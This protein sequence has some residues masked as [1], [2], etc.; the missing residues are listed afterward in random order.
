MSF[1]QS[2]DC[3][4]RVQQE[5]DVYNALVPG[6]GEL[7]ATLFIE[8]PELVRMSQDEVRETVNRFQGLEKDT[9]WMVAVTATLLKIEIGARTTTHTPKRAGEPSARGSANWMA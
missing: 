9:V 6:Q 7:S 4:A 2:P 5:L 1:L 8:I 3:P